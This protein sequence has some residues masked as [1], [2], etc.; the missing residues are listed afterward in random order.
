MMYYAIQ[1]DICVCLGFLLVLIF[2][3]SCQSGKSLFIGGTCCIMIYVLCLYLVNT[4]KL[5]IIDIHLNKNDYLYVI[6][7]WL[8]GL[9]CLLVLIFDVGCQSCE[10]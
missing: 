4:F 3:L 7:M 10:S 5:I 1:N 9:G 8:G 6:C 2:D